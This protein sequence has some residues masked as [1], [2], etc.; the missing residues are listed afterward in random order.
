M[1][2]MKSI[3]AVITVVLLGLL[4]AFWT[5]FGSDLTLGQTAYDEEQQGLKERIIIKFS[6]VVAENTPKGLAAD[7]FA[8]LVSEK[9]HGKVE[10]QIY[11]NGILYSDENEFDAL[12]RGDVQMIAPAF[13]KVSNLVPAWL[14]LDLPYAFPNQEAV[15]QA[16]Q[17]EIGQ[18]LFQSLEQKNMLGLAYWNNGF[19]QMT[20]KLKPLVTQEDFAGQRFRIMASKVLEDQFRA[21]H[22]KPVPISFSEVFRSFERDDV[23]AQENTISNIYTKRLYQVQR[24]MTLSNHGYLGYAV[25]VNKSFWEKLPPDIQKEVR[26]AMQETT[27]WANRQAESMNEAQL[28]LLQDSGIHIHQLNP[29]EQASWEQAFAP[30]YDK[31]TPIIGSELMEKIRQ[32]RKQKE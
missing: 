8:S 2:S 28:R 21:L 17:G 31:Y 19:K 5:G 20:S 12:I 29:Q 15:D 22:A 11:P 27:A 7:K 10:V 23:D 25:I 13:S 32:L 24:F 1:F 3:I 18:M 26:Q 14:A 9:T 4:A 6:H 30:V 16:L